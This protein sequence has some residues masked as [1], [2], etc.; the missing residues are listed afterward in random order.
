MAAWY[1]ARRGSR[2]GKLFFSSSCVRPAVVGRGNGARE[3]LTGLGWLDGR[4]SYNRM[5]GGRVAPADT[6][7]MD[8][9]W[10]GGRATARGWWFTR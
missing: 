8:A 10:S 4:G 6:V 3:A 1:N 7:D 2:L 9:T 5:M